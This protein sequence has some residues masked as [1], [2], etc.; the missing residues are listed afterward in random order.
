MTLARFERYMGA[1]IARDQDLGRERT[2]REFISEFRGLSGSA[3]QKAVLEEVG[4]ARSSLAGYFGNGEADHAANARLLAACQKHTRPVKP[5]DIGLI[6][7]DHLEA[8]FLA[9]GVAPKSFN[10]FRKLDVHKGVPHVA[11]IAFGYTPNATARRIISGVNWS[12]AI[13]NPFRSFGREAENLGSLLAAQ[14]AG[15]EEPVHWLIHLASPRIDYADRGK[16]AV[17]LADDEDDE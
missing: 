6:G 17:I 8:I 7:K 4:A 12:V 3:K 15:R 16:T 1:H 5:V 13:D 11:E 10:Y 2:V 9:A 14:R